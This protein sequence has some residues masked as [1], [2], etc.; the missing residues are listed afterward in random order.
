MYRRSHSFSLNGCARFLVLRIAADLRLAVDDLAA[1]FDRVGDDARID[2][3]A[4][5]RAAR[6][7][8]NHRILHF[9]RG[10]A[11][12][13][14]TAAQGVAIGTMRALERRIAAELLGSGL[15]DPVHRDV[16]VLVQLD[17]ARAA[18]HEQREPGGVDGPPRSTLPISAICPT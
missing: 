11:A 3:I 16:V 6:R 9:G 13:R 14:R 8:A 5:P 4:I 7:L 2:R 18:Q 15:P 12:A 1:A 10:A 17:V